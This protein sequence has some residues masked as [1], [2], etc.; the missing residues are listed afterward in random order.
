MSLSDEDLRDEA[1]ACVGEAVRVG[2][3][4]L[5]AFVAD[6]RRRVGNVHIQMS[7]CFYGRTT[8]VRCRVWRWM[9]AVHYV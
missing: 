5:V 2:L 1:P 6:V 8:A 3:L 4:E 7:P 9:S